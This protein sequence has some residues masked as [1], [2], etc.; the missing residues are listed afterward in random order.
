MVG[1]SS[2]VERLRHI[3]E[4]YVILSDLAI[5]ILDLGPL[6]SKKHRD[7]VEY[8]RSRPKIAPIQW[9]L[10]VFW[11]LIDRSPRPRLRDPE[12]IV[13]CT[14]LVWFVD[15]GDLDNVSDHLGIWLELAISW[16]I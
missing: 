9:N 7:F 12:S 8:E 4:F 6:E 1:S 10:G 15:S 13:L 16:I 14:E 3:D 5:S 11:T 2:K